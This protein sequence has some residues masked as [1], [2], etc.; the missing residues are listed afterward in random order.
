MFRLS[1]LCVVTV[2]GSAAFADMANNESHLSV[3]ERTPEDIALIQSVTKPT[4][5]F[6]QAEEFEELAG[7]DTTT[8]TMSSTDVFSQ[9]STNILQRNKLDFQIG[10]GLF[11]RSWQPAQTEVTGSD[12]LGPLFNTDACQACHIRN[13]RGHPPASA[14]GN[15]MSFV[16]R[17]S[18]PDTTAQDTQTIE[19]YFASKP[20]PTYGLQLQDFAL[21]GH[22]PEAQIQVAYEYITIPL[23]EGEAATLRQPKYSVSNTA[24]GPLHPDTQYSPRVAQKMIGLG[25][26]E[27]VATEDILTLADPED[28]NGDGISG[29][30]NSVRSAEFGHEMLGR[31][32]HKASMPTLR[33][34]TA[35]ALVADM[36]L[37][38]SVFS[39][40][41]G[42]CTSDQ[43]ECRNAPHGIHATETHEV[44]D[45]ALDLLTLYTRNLAVPARRNVNDPDV[46]RGKQV[47]YET[48]CTS[49]HTP[50]FV[51]QRLN[52]QDEQS[53]QLIWPYTDLLLHDMGDGLADNRPEA[54]ATGREWRTP[55]LWGIGLTSQVSEHT[56]FLHDGR[57]RSLL[58]AV[59]WHGGEAE[60]QKDAVV[61]MPKTD[62]DA[63][64]TFL[65]SL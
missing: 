28:S 60:A 35:G 65:E 3:I 10:N 43:S 44:G 20:E 50:K 64:I 34:Q 12:G 32:G 39:M 2:F 41:W 56:Y 51:T 63:L 42:D 36:G 24:Y 57:A 33:E 31:F 47:F 21:E 19:G 17:V 37:S 26:L 7:G 5:D 18:I 25:L 53:F 4:T 52:D 1:A 16:M 27:A 30:P 14:E 38:T 54:G 49:C 13:G 29:R 11:K 62:R 9:P 55:P 8:F 15:A 23:S 40:P 61:S 46:L 22:E 6:T 45:L 48:G 58:E 59:L